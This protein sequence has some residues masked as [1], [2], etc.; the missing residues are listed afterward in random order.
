M[1]SSDQAAA[2]TTAAA[3]EGNTKRLT[4]AAVSTSPARIAGVRK[5]LRAPFHP[6]GGERAG[7]G[8]SHLAGQETSLQTGDRK[9]PS[10]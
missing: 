5:I 2:R 7:T 6:G 1:N 8:D 10:M 4:Y 3:S 9:S